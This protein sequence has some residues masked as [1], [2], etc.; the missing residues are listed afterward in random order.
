MILDDLRRAYHAGIVRDLMRVTAE[1]TPNFADKSSDTSTAIARRIT[2]AMPE[3]PIMGRVS[4]QKAG[5]QFELLTAHFL[6]SAFDHL[7]HLRPGTW[8]FQVTNTTLDQFEQYTHLADLQAVITQHPEL[9]AALGGDYIIRPDV[10][11]SRSPVPDDHIN[12]T[13]D[14]VSTDS[15]TLSPLRAENRPTGHQILHAVVSCKWTIRSDRAQNTRTEALNLIRN[16]KGHLP[17][18]VA[19]TA[20]PYANR[21]A[22]L[23]LGTGDLDCVYH[24]ALY[25]LVDAA[26]HISADQ[27]DLLQTMIDGRRATA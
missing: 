12:Q 26:R 15:G 18:I 9:T 5:R 20:E 23:C 11:I 24:F 19:V 22:A 3:E 21:L 13:A 14:V 25:E 8:Q 16:R 27:Y 7:A 17:H 10:V 6:Q 4:G 1:G 2:Q